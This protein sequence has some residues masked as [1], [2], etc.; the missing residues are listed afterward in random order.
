MDLILINGA[1][2]RSGQSFA[3]AL[4]VNHGRITAVGANEEILR[5]RTHQSRCIDAGG[6]LVLPGF[7]DSHV[8]FLEG[9]F[10]LLG[11]DLRDAASPAEMGRRLAHA[12]AGLP[13]GN[14]ISGGFWDHERWPGK[15]LPHRALIDAAVPDHPVFVVRLDWHMGVANSQA[16]R[17][18]GIDADTP[19][20]AGGAID[21]DPASGAPT[22]ILRDEAMR[23]ITRILPAPS[24]AERQK[25]AGSAMQHAARL[26]VTTVQ[27][28]CTA[29][30]LA[31]YRALEQEGKLKCRISAWHS[32]AGPED[33]EKMAGEPKLDTP[34]LRSGT[35]KLFSDGSFGAST[36]WLFEPYEGS[37]ANFGL[38]IHAPEMLQKM[39]TRIDALGWQMA[40]HAIGDRAVHETLT[41]LE[42]AQAANAAGARRHRIEHAQMVRTQDMPRFKKLGILASLQPSHAIDDLRWIADRIGTRTALAYRYR[43]FVEHGI[44]VALGTD[45]TVEP[46]TPLLTLYAAVTREKPGGGPAGGWHSRECV[47]LAQALQDY[48]RGSAFAMGRETVQGALT[49]GYYA[50]FI[51]L[52][53]NLFETNP[54]DWLAAGVDVTVVAGEVI[55][56][57]N[58]AVG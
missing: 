31:F 47:G 10:H 43:S 35:A 29:E 45:W 1:I 41:A 9:G 51:V 24:T 32:V 20:P 13:P 25:A 48:T 39:V 58:N 15:P 44:P 34:L 52:D 49:P 55:Y 26:G 3:Q 33:V 56:D 14:W 27:G 11:V 30:E 28:S 19:S 53:Q 16:L 36:A 40:I 2:W 37:A 5:L 38:A 8:H 4:A 57:R 22:G 50:D 12:A 46:L 17:L 18:A 54:R 23:L 42:R 7:N 6:R 21:L